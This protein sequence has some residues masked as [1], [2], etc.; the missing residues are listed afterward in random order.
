MPSAEHEQ[1]IAHHDDVEIVWVHGGNGHGQSRLEEIL[2][3]AE[4]PAGT[5]YIWV[6]GETTAMRGAR[7]YLRHELKLPSS[8]YKVIGYWIAK[9]EEWN[10]RYEALPAQTLAELTALWATDR[11]EEEIEDEYVARLVALGL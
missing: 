10:A 7:R 11:D 1:H 3:S 6:A 4:L 2:R 9:A 8:A 5:G